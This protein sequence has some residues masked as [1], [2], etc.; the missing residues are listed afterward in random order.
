M[1]LCY[2]DF[3]LEDHLLRMQIELDNLIWER[4]E[5]HG[6][7]QTADKEIRILESMLAEVEEENDKAIAKIEFLEVEVI[8]LPSGKLS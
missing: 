6:Q 2:Y 1:L 5:L 4:K 7:L 3:Q 8:A